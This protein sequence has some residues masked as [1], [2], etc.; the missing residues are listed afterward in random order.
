MFVMPAKAGI[1]VHSWFRIEGLDSGV[2]RNDGNESR[3]PSANSDAL[4]L[5]HD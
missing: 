3:L 4:A 1:Q 5:N 2:C